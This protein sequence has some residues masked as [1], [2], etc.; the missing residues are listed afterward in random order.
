MSEQYDS[1]PDT[2]A[3]IRRV[4]YLNYCFCGFLAKQVCEHDRSKLRDPE[5][6][7]FDEFT[8]KLKHSTYGSD[9]YKQF[10]ADMQMGLKHHYAENRH[11]PEHFEN[12]IRDMTLIDIVEMLLDWKAASERHGD[13]D[14]FRSIELNQGRFGYSD[15]LKMI[16]ANTARILKEL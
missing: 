8:P 2:Q 5:K 14:L 13:G 12:G 7:I 10:L 9:E 4:I 16:L 6:A 1:R 3:H 11:H 15:D